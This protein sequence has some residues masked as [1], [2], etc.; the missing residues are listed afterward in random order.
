MQPEQQAFIVAGT[1]RAFDAIPA[2][3]P[4]ANEDCDYR[5]REN[6]RSRPAG[7]PQASDT[8]SPHDVIAE[9]ENHAPRT[10][11]GFCGAR[12]ERDRDESCA[13]NR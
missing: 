11:T 1:Q 12:L 2:V 13:C 10:F 6:P 7:I 5:S 4:A 8:G 3:P 9:V